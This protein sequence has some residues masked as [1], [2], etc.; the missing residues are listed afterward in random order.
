MQVIEIKDDCETG[1]RKRLWAVGMAEH[2]EGIVSK[3][4]GHIVRV[5]TILHL[6]AEVAKVWSQTKS[7]GAFLR[8]I[9]AHV[10]FGSTVVPDVNSLELLTNR[11][12]TDLLSFHSSQ[13]KLQ[14]LSKSVTVL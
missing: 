5:A 13:W 4:P 1:A 12:Y 3:L 10:I 8:A 9:G 11:C 2:G 7:V 6:F 14:H